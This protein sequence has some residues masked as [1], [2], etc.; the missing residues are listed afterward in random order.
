LAGNEP[1]AEEIERFIRQLG[2]RPPEESIPG[3]TLVANRAIIE[4]HRVARGQANQQ[5]GQESWGK[6]ARL[7]NAVRSGVLQLASIRDSV[8]GLGLAPSGDAARAPIPPD[9][10]SVPSATVPTD[11]S[12]LPP[13]IGEGDPT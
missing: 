1:T 8:K 13:A 6:W 3:L 11:E 5:R 4:L 7:A 2:A 9:E 12:P 10:P